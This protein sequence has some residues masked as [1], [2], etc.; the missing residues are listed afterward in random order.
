M[1]YLHAIR[2]CHYLFV[3]RQTFSQTLTWAIERIQCDGWSCDRVKVHLA[4]A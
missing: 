1:P 4:L 3:L 2:D